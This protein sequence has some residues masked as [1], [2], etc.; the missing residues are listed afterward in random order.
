MK[1]RKN[2]RRVDPRYFLDETIEEIEKESN[3]ARQERLK[4]HPDF[5]NFSFDSWLL[6]EAPMSFE[7]FAAARR[8][9]GHPEDSISMSY[10]F[11][12]DDQRYPDNSAHQ[13]TKDQ[14][15]RGLERDEYLRSLEE[16]SG[17]LH[18]LRPSSDELPSRKRRETTPGE[19]K[20]ASDARER[21]NLRRAE[22]EQE[23]KNRLSAKFNK[24][25]LEEDGIEEGCGDPAPMK[26]RIAQAID[27]LPNLMDEEPPLDE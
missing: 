13:Q 14:L 11:Y 7:E 8:L 9:E 22:E 15:A 5:H 4:N 24:R 18:E 1:R 12:L 20:A 6:K 16:A 23:E 10:Q 26:I 2:T 21:A 19:I 17:D 25:T 3:S 27:Q